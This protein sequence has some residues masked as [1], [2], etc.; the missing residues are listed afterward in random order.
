MR[1]PQ[2]S[3][4]F[5]YTTLFRSGAAGTGY[6]GRRKNPYI[7]GYGGGFTGSGRSRGG[8]EPERPADRCFPLLRAR[9]AKCQYYRFGGAYYSPANRDGCFLS[10]RKVAVKKQGKSLKDSPGQTL[11]PNTPGTTGRVGQYP[12]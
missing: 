5:P 10:G 4:L 1:Y 9:R 3:T 12:P 11:G 2:K 6:R 7:C 8:T